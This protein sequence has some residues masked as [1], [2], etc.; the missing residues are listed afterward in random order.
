MLEKD[1]ERDADRH[2]DLAKD[3]LTLTECIFALAIALT[4]VSLHAVFLGKTAFSYF[5]VAFLSE[6]FPGSY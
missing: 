5:T 6:A 2:I 1:E 4:C 3:K